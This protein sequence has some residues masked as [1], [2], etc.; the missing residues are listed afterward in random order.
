MKKLFSLVV[1]LSLVISST[2]SA[3][4]ISELTTNNHK[5]K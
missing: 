5:L 2:V 4:A 3:Y 1:A